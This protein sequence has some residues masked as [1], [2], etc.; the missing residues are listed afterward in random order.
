MKHPAKWW[1]VSLAILAAP[2]LLMAHGHPCAH[3]HAGGGNSTCTPSGAKCTAKGKTGTCQDSGILSGQKRCRCIKATTCGYETLASLDPDVPGLPGSGDVR[4][5]TVTS[6]PSNVSQV[7]AGP[8]LETEFSG[9]TDPLQ[10]T[11]TLQYGSFA[12][13]ANVPVTVLDVSLTLASY[14]TLGTAT[15]VSDI[16]LGAPGPQDLIYDSTT[17][18]IG[19]LG[20]ADGI[21]V[22]V[23]NDIQVDS[24]TTVWF[25]AEVAPDGTAILLAGAETELAISIPGLGWKGALL[26]AGLL[27]AVAWFAIPRLRK[28]TAGNA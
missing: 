17:G 13:P 16:H 7:Y 12:D 24:P 23:T 10:G 4:V 15:G 11:L 3:A 21:E 26:L 2:T 19:P 6:D 27:A 14:E 25:E 20:G 18:I 28:R 9:V 8:L 22:A 1:F 5:Y